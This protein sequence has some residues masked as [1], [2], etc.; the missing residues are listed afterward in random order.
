M[1]VAAQAQPGDCVVLLHGLARTARSMN[2]MARR[3]TA[4]GY[5]VV[6]LSYPSTRYP[7]EQ[8]ATK[9]LDRSLQQCSQD[10]V[11]IHFVTHSMGGIL[12]RQYLVEN[13]LPRL[14]RAVM[15]APPNHGSEAVDR[16]GDLPGFF[17]INGPAGLQLSTAPDSVPNSLGPVTF[18]LGV[19]AG[20]VNYNPV[21]EGM[22][23]KPH[24][25]KVSVASAKVEGMA[26]F[27]TVERTHSFIMNAPEVIEQTLA[28]LAD[29]RF[30]R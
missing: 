30:L 25:G 10:A 12:L 9:A 13:R 11:N 4:A 17:L 5:R 27:I 14:G 15:L 8:L 24:D 1:E 7:I 26:D 21:L 16:L 2:P 22:L 23:P 6:N 3:L 20:T 18:P 19:I 29:G 28:F